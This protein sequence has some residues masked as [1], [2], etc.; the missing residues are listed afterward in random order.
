MAK[1]KRVRTCCICGVRFLGFG[2]N[3]RPVKTKGTCCNECHREE[4]KPA[5]TTEEI[6]KYNKL[7]VEQ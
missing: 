5:R 4:V 3:P 2:N 6:R 1:K 7:L